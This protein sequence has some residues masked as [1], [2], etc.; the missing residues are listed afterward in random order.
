MRHFKKEGR[1]KPRHT[2]DEKTIEKYL[3]DGW[4]EVDSKGVKL[5]NKKTSSKKKKS[6]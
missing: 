4:Y 2:D 1:I 5:G 6:E 3:G